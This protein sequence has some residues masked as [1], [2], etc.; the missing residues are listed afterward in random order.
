MSKAPRELIIEEYMGKAL[1]SS[2]D[3][4]WFVSRDEKYEVIEKT[5]EVV[6]KLE[7]FDELV[8][9]VSDLSIT[10]AKHLVPHEKEICEKLLKKAKGE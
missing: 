9:T 4:K 7:C 5:P 6:R 3:G 10:L 2:K 8:Q 1:V